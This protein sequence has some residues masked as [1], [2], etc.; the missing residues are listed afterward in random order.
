MNSPGLTFVIGA[1]QNF[2]LYL[3]AQ[4]YSLQPLVMLFLIS[5]YVHDLHVYREKEIHKHI[6]NHMNYIKNKLYCISH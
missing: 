4:S 3:G 5:V 1:V 6:I 2:A